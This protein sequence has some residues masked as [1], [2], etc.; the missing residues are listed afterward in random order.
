MTTKKYKLSVE[1]IAENL[2]M[3]S[4]MT[5]G[6]SGAP[7]SSDLS[8][9]NEGILDNTIIRVK[10]WFQND[11]EFYDQ[12][13][14]F[15]KGLNKIRTEGDNLKQF[16]SKKTKLKTGAPMISLTSPDIVLMTT[17]AGTP[18]TFEEFMQTIEQG[19][20]FYKIVAEQAVKDYEN[21]L[22]VLIDTS[23]MIIKDVNQ[24][25]AAYASLCKA[26]YPNLAAKKLIK[27]SP[28]VMV[29]GA[30]FNAASDILA[31]CWVLTSYE[32]TTFSKPRQILWIGRAKKATEL[33]KSSYSI[34]GFQPKEVMQLL[35]ACADSADN[36]AH[37]I[38]TSAGTRSLY[39]Q[40]S[41]AI[42]TY[43]SFVR[44]PEVTDMENIVKEKLARY[45]DII[46]HEIDEYM[47]P[48]YKAQGAYFGQLQ[49]I[50]LIC[51]KSITRME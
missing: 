28:Q 42:N 27:N 51:K 24:I 49:T 14:N 33:A 19:N 38:D 48:F 35:D 8:V 21:F 4:D 9:A 23:K 30:K 22:R 46:Y 44:T 13:V 26:A 12:K 16:L 17:Q 15:Q 7:H 6:A 47:T 1:E 50:M 31:A 45:L 10:E 39:S 41:T 34:P 32:Q 37:S 3:I 40:G 29:T 25:D 18:K 5:I 11:A 36:F 43:L 2:D 20:A